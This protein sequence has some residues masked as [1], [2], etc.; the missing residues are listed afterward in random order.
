[1]NKELFLPST[2]WG[3]GHK[4]FLKQPKFLLLLAGL[5]LPA[6]ASGPLGLIAGPLLVGPV[7][8]LLLSKIIVWLIQR[9][10]EKE[11]RAI[12]EAFP[13]KYSEAELE[14]LREN[15]P[16]E[17]K[18]LYKLA[19]DEFFRKYV[20]EQAE[21]KKAQELIQQLQERLNMMRERLT[22]LEKKEE[23]HKKEIDELREH[24]KM[25]EDIFNQWKKAA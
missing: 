19:S 10:R 17:F 9:E 1:M 12:Q 7:Y 18:R 23:K 4:Y 3:E 13:G 11:K 6:I 21:H 25:Y 5:G 24:V 14:D 20:E 22:K 16:K 8:F 2:E 15:N